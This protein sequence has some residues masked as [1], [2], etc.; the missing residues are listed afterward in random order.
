MGFLLDHTN[1]TIK[2]VIALWEMLLV[3]R[4]G[5]QKRIEGGFVRKRFG[6]LIKQGKEVLLRKQNSMLKSS[7]GI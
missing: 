1:F 6:Q 4:R 5:R 2:T 7:M 3:G